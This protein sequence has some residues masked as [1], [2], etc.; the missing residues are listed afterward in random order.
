MEE[1]L[2]KVVHAKF[3]D[4]NPIEILRQKTDDPYQLGVKSWKTFSKSTA[5]LNFKNK[6]EADKFRV[7][8]KDYGLHSKRP[9]KKPYEFRIH[10]IPL[11]CTKLDVQTKLKEHTGTEIDSVK[12]IAYKNIKDS[13]L[14]LIE[15]NK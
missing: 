5:I 8:A 2:C 10:R 1:N 11:K 6:D 3:P 4:E 14:A 7:K 13:N 15:C 9:T 12:I